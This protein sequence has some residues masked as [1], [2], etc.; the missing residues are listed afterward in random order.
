MA[1]LRC[2]GS[3]SE[4]NCYIIECS[5]EILIL[6]LGVSFKDILKALNY[7]VSKVVGACVT[8]KHVDHAKYLKTAFKYAI[9][10]YS[11]K[12]VQS[13]DE[14]VKVLEM[15]LKTQIGGFKVQPLNVPHSVEC[16]S[17]I[18][19]HE[20]FGK[21]LFATDCSS[22]KYRIKNL[23]HILIESNWSEEILIDNMCNDAD[24]RSRHEQHLEINDTIDAIKENYSSC[25]QNVLLLHL[26]NGNS[27]EVDFVKK[28]KNEIGLPNVFCAKENLVVSLYE[29]EF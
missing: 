17:F 24:M 2:L 4:G 9:N 22:F 11:C 25:L 5:N 20:E 23:N 7:D 29:S 13:I 19:Q 15:G 3:S 8:H 18:I 26:S 1:T 27:N 21:L 6:E 14:R 12:D 10:V 28:V 16:Y